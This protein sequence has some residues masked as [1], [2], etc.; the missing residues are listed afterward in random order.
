MIHPR[1]IVVAEADAATR[2]ML[3]MALS[4]LLGTQVC[5]M[6]GAEAAIGACRHRPPDLLVI[7]AALAGLPASAFVARLRS[8][9][10]MDSVPVVFTSDD[11]SAGERRRLEDAGAGAVVIKPFDPLTIGPRLCRLWREARARL[12][13]A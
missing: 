3:D 6:A 12:T 7:D 4:G 13:P 11:V 1:R 5:M 8:N 2:E 9:P 10:G